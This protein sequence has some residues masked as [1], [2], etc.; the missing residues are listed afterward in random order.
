MLKFHHARN[1]VIKFTGTI[2]ANATVFVETGIEK[3]YT[4]DNAT[5]GALYCST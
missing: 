1:A 2:T 5:T 4:V 3:T